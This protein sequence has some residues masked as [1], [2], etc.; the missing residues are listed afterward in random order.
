MNQPLCL[1]TEEKENEFL[2]DVSLGNH[3]AGSSET[4]LYVGLL[5]VPDGS[6]SAFGAYTR[7]QSPFSTHELLLRFDPEEELSKIY[8]GS[9]LVTEIELE[10]YEYLVKPILYSTGRPLRCCLLY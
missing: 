6:Y 2:Q 5:F 9:D 4:E 7:F 1:V 10:P 8:I 3:G